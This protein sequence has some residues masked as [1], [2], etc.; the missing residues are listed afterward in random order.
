MAS[1]V[2]GFGRV[3]LN[4]SSESP[5]G[6]EDPRQKSKEKDKKDKEKNK[7]DKKKDKNRKVKDDDKEEKK[8]KKEDDSADD[9][10]RGIDEGEDGDDPDEADDD[11]A[12]PKGTCKKPAARKPRQKKTAKDSSK[13]EK[14]KTKS[15]GKKKNDGAEDDSPFDHAMQ[16]MSL[17]DVAMMAEN[18]STDAVSLQPKEDWVCSLVWLLRYTVSHKCC[19][20]QCQIKFFL[21]Q[22]DEDSQKTLRLDDFHDKDDQ[23]CPKKLIPLQ[24]FQ[25]FP[26]LSNTFQY[27][28]IL[29]NTFQYF[30]ILSN[31]FQYFPFVLRNVANNCRFII[32]LAYMTWIVHF[33]VL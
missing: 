28:P 10:F 16:E 32:E 11:A 21:E 20:F 29:S 25:Y 5:K 30:P 6:D 7:D 14:S 15:K 1:E 13:K 3:A 8:K 24:S 9:V 17:K 33:K 27:F 31:T 23:D 4:S 18:G 19:W 26:I 2:S 22:D 12:E